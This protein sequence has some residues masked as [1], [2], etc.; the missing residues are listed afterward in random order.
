MAVEN[1][2]TRQHQTPIRVLVVDD[3]ALLRGALCDVL[4]SEG[5]DVAQAEDGAAALDLLQKTDIDLLLTDIQMPIMDGIDL[6]RRALQHDPNLAAILVTGHA[7]V[8]SAV[9]AM[10]I[11]AIDYIQKPFRTSEIMPIV[12]RALEIRRLRLENLD[13]RESVAVHEMMVAVTTI[14]DLSVVVR[15]VAEA[16][17][18][19]ADA[20]EAS[21]VLAGQGAHDLVVAA[22]SGTPREQLVG[23]HVSS[24]KSIASWVARTGETLYLVGEVSDPRFSPEHPRA[25]I[26]AS[27]TLPL[28]AGGRMM[29]VLNLNYTSKQPPL[30]HG[31]TKALSLLASI[32]AVALDSARAQ[33]E[34]RDAEAR[35]RSV[36][37]N[38]GEG[39]FRMLPDGDLI[40][41]NPAYSQMLGYRNP[42]DLI[43]DSSRINICDKNADDHPV[44]GPVDTGR[45]ELAKA[46]RRGD[47]TFVIETRVR[48][49]D[50]LEAWHEVSLKA[51]KDSDGQVIWFDGIARDVTDRRKLEAEAAR[52]VAQLQSLRN[53]DLAITSSTDLR[54]VMEVFHAQVE[55]HCNPTAWGVMR[56]DPQ[57]G[58]LETF[59]Y[60]GWAP[61]LPPCPR[62]RLGEGHE[63][64][65]TM[66]RRVVVEPELADSEPP[67][68]HR[69]CQERDHARSLVV[70]PLIAKGRVM[71][72][73]RLFYKERFEPDA[74]W[75]EYLETLA[76]QGAIALDNA[77]LFGDLT[78]ARDDLALAYETTIEG[79]AR[80]LDLRDKET[81]GHSRRVTEITVSLARQMGIKPAELVHVRRGALLH[82]V[83]K[84]G[85]PDSI[86]LK[87]GQLDPDERRVIERHASFGRDL[88]KPIRFLAPA[89]DIPW[90]HHERWDGS[91]YPRRLTGDEIPIGARIFAVVD[92]WDALTNDRP[93]RKAMSHDVALSLI[94]EGAGS[95]FDPEVVQ[96]FIEEIGRSYFPSML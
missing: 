89:M 3:E 34:A 37:E 96:V 49:I 64:R 71:G 61:L 76:G 55:R 29:G 21:I 81:E 33:E 10:K 2:A 7:T 78:V 69:E 59:S 9:E 5:Y 35:F 82:D 63:G 68:E 22:T 43:A 73:L 65:A 32:A 30:T 91:G 60:R 54:V 14:P 86:L 36:F 87:P 62:L 75:L 26:L 20:D 80:A 18:H 13:L 74:A 90:C 16:A 12:R 19:Q 44:S 85:I 88:L 8:Q 23:L 58:F 77:A 52:R 31:R 6:L 17:L 15:K 72:V 47:G 1:D 45:N 53:I 51:V 40:V 42:E 50:G 39:V 46:L 79:W 66:E 56:L 93:Y 92:V 28:K 38:V 83:G 67:C 41:A 4:E 24:P 94:E 70:A 48:R 11:G 27:R 84:M 25:D 95:H 57:S